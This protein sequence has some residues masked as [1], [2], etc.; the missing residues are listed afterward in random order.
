[1]LVLKSVTWLGVIA[2]GFTAELITVNVCAVGL[3]GLDAETKLLKAK[4][5]VE[6]G[7][8]VAKFETAI[9][10]AVLDVFCDTLRSRVPPA[11]ITKSCVYSV[12]LVLATISVPLP[13]TRTSSTLLAPE[14]IVPLT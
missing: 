14:R 12:L 1:M 6:L 13:S 3:F 9:I 7:A 8:M 5:I 10:G 4:P 11:L 2:I